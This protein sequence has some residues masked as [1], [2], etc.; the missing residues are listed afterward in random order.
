LTFVLRSESGTMIGCQ[1]ICGFEDSTKIKV[2]PAAQYISEHPDVVALE[3]RDEEAVVKL[4]SASFVGNS[5]VSAEGLLGWVFRDL[6]G[7]GSAASLRKIHRQCVA[8]YCRYC[9]VL[10]RHSG[11]RFGIVDHPGR[12]GKRTFKA[13]M[14][15]FPPYACPNHEVAPFLRFLGTLLVVGPPFEDANAGKL[16]GLYKAI[17]LRRRILEASLRECHMNVPPDD[18]GYWYLQMLGTSPRHRGQNLAK[19]LVSF[20]QTVACGDGASI[21]LECHRDVTT[22]YERLGFE[23]RLPFEHDDPD[24][25]LDDTAR[26]R[27]DGMICSP[28]VGRNPI[29]YRPFGPPFVF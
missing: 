18:G 24:A 9:F 16:K 29:V 23:S 22:F 1:G 13:A 7:P 25:P 4:L 10:G 12:P 20:L 6:T 27:G 5:E 21:Y 26:L 14:L 3:D 15:T 28:F 2:R 17:V 11:R 8:Y 19:K